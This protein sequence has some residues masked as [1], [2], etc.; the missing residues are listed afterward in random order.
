MSDSIKKI[1]KV[2][3]KLTKVVAS[4]KKAPAEPTSKKP[5]KKER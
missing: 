3:E 1:A 5:S 4:V 2:V